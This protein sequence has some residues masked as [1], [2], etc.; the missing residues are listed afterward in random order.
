VCRGLGE[1]SGSEA[2]HG[3]LAVLV[4]LALND[5]YCP[6]RTVP[7]AI[8]EAVAVAVADEPCLSI[9]ELD[10]AFVARGDAEAAA[11]ALL[12]VNV[13]NATQ[14]VNSFRIF[15]YCNTSIS[16]FFAGSGFYRS[17]SANGEGNQP[18]RR[19]SRPVAAFVKKSELA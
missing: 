9:H 17:G 12:L 5:G 7:K 18:S 8:A 14:H 1:L 4:S 11:V 16:A 6:L 19:L 2:F 3:L 15:R 10:G 13:D